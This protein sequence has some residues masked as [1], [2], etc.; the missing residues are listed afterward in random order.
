MSKNFATRQSEHGFYKTKTAAERQP[1]AGDLSM[2]TSHKNILHIDISQ[3]TSCTQTSYTLK[4]SL[5]TSRRR[6]SRK[7]IY[8]TSVSTQNS[9][10][11]H[12]SRKHP[13]HTGT[14]CVLTSPRQTSQTGIFPI[15]QTTSLH[16]KF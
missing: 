15:C 11:V 12:L 7:R 9:I 8:Y 5:G 1:V 10:K 13:A 6:R 3:G 16:S 14:S 4:A 2:D